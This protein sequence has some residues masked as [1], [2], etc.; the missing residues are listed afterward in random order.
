MRERR[1]AACS[2]RPTNCRVH[3]V[4][5]Q[6]IVRPS[7]RV[8]GV[9]LGLLDPRLGC[10]TMATA[11][12][13]SATAVSYSCAR[14]RSSRRAGSS[15]D[16]LTGAASVARLAC[17][18]LSDADSTVSMVDRAAALRTGVPSLCR[19]SRGSPS[20]ARGSRSPFCRASADDFDVVVT[21]RSRTSPPLPRR[22]R[23]GH[24]VALAPRRGARADEPNGRATHS[25]LFLVT[26]VPGPQLPRSYANV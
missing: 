6:A 9:D 21:S 5:R 2:S 23:L 3:L 19:R 14:S 4:R 7:T 18:L 25:L 10:V 8:Y 17:R 16:F 24:L 12:F 11:A 13:S 15:A 20:T 26:L 22:R 1:A